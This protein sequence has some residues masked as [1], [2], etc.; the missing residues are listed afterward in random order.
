MIIGERVRLRGIEESD[1][2]QFVEW[3]NDPEVR[4]NLLVDMP[5]SMAN[6]KNWFA[7]ILQQS[8]YE[9]PLGIE[10]REGDGWRLIG[11]LSLMG[12][13]WKEQS[14][15]VGIFIGDK[16]CWNHGYGQEAMTLLLD[17]AFNEWNFHRIWL[18]VYAT[19]MRAIRAYEKVG[20]VYEGRMREAK[21]LHGQFIDFLLMSVLRSEW[22]EH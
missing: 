8:P 17:T 14:A 5:L 6:E 20:F 13:K 1:L 11:N 15:E 9:Q 19:N 2:P 4:E 16:S 22:N 21:F 10:I 7:S 3:L 18:R 12:I